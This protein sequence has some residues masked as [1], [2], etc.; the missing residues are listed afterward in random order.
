MMTKKNLSDLMPGSEQFLSLL[1]SARQK[2]SK[3]L[4]IKLR[5]QCI[6]KVYLQELNKKYSRGQ[7]I[8]IRLSRQMKTSKSY[9]DKTLTEFNHS[10]TIKNNLPRG[11]LLCKSWYSSLERPA[12]RT[13]NAQ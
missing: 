6:E 10:A 12:Q 2:K 13:Q 8:S 9:I 11:S 3:S 5:Q 1:S 7:N 4:L